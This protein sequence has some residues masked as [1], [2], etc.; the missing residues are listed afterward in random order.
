MNLQYVRY[1]LEVARTGSISK[2]A[3]NLSVAQPNL[4]RAVKELESQLGIAIFDRTRTGMSVTPEGDKFLSAGERILR[5]VAEL[6]GMFDGSDACAVRESMSI[7]LPSAAYLSAA[8][9]RFCRSLSDGGRYD[10]TFREVGAL[11]AIGCVLRGE[12]RLGIIRYAASF[13]TYYTALLDEK[14]LAHE[15]LTEYRP[16]L[17]AGLGSPLAL[18]DEVDTSDLA[19]LYALDHPDA[20]SPADDTDTSPRF[21]S[22]VVGR[23]AQYDILSSDPRAYLYTV[24]M[25]PAEAA[26]MGLVCRPAA[27]SVHAPLYRDVLIHQKGYRPS[28]QERT[29]I[30]YMRE[31]LC[32]DETM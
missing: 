29:M 11:D 1:A 28:E 6:E 7:S 24:P 14:G 10:L 22:T 21:R 27:A 20:L 18:C 26:R 15:V 3:D 17:A 16:V 5:D 9:A 32:A 25:A 12:S 4:S 13:E 19:T 30:K 23:A 2:A 31:G 8:Y